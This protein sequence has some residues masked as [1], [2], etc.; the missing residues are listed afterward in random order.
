MR[1]LLITAATMGALAIPTVAHAQVNTLAGAG[2]G[3]VTGAVI[4][5][6]P[7]A[8]IGGAIGGSVGLATEPRGRV[9]VV[10][11]NRYAYGERVCWLDSAGYRHCRV[12]RVQ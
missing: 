7:G 10:P 9:Y 4:G 12:Q 6:P 5:G 1:K 3:A 8:L 2:V 11:S